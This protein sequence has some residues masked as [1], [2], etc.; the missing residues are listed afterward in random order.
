M[1]RTKILC[2]KAGSKFRISIVQ[3]RHYYYYTELTAVCISI[4]ASTS[5]QNKLILYVLEFIRVVLRAF[6]YT[7]DTSSVAL[8]NRSRALHR[9]DSGPVVQD[10]A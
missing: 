10:T 4:H 6:P 9:M 1:I 3:W 5:L 7:I 2:R 8:R